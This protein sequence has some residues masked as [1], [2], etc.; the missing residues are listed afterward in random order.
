MSFWGFSFRRTTLRLQ[1]GINRVGAWMSLTGV[2]YMFS[3]CLEELV[4]TA[5]LGLLD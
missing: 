3:F 2:V 4:T 5:S 1:N